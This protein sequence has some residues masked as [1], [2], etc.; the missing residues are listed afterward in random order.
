MKNFYLTKTL[1][2]TFITVVVMVTSCKTNNEIKPL[3]KSLNEKVQEFVDI[4]YNNYLADNEGFPGGFAIRVIYGDEIGFGY[5]G[6]DENFSESV[7]FRGQSTTKTFTAAA[8]VLLFQR[9]LLQLD[10][11]VT[12][13]IPGKEITYLPSTEDYNIPF[14]NQISIFQLLHHTAGV[15]DLVNH[16]EGEQFVDSVFGKDPEFTMTIDL[17]TSYISSHH[18]YEFEP[19]DSWAYSNSGFQLLAK[20]I[21]RVSDKSYQK[22]ITDEFVIPLEL[23]E[24]SFP[25]KGYEQTLPDP[26]VDSWMWVSGENYNMTEENISANV[27]EGNMITSP[28]DLCKFYE[29]L[30]KGKAGIEI[31]YVSNYVMN[32]VPAKPTSSVGYGT[33]LFHYVNLGYGHGGDGSGIS[34]KCYTDQT[35]E[36]TVFILTN[37]WNFKNGLGDMSPAMEEAMMLHN[38]M[39]DVKELVVGKY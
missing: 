6:F 37:C 32:C 12:D 31:S 28:R 20:I 36:F 33:G 14:K 27:G 16:S 38:L 26:F 30:L 19:G 25:D 22:F 10:A 34:V 35:N 21:E 7:H 9:G 17:M 3:A 29:L 11:L 24:T 39:F 5:D 23:N 4:T 1:F 18:L 13:T 8:I 2:I 15:Y